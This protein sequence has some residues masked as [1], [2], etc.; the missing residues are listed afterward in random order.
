[1]QDD[2]L[3]TK[4]SDLTVEGVISLIERVEDLKPALAKL[5]PILRENAIN[6]RVLKYCELND[7]KKVTIF[8]T[9]YMFVL[10]LFY[11][12]FKSYLGTKSKFWTLG[13]VPFTNH[14]NAWLWK[15]AA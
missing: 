15:D 11:K 14:H 5:S 2:I 10:I 7:L 8:I 3:Q 1:M 6:G 9:F 4:L 13:A 12:I